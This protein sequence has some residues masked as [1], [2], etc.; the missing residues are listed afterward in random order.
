MRAST[1]SSPDSSPDERRYLLV[2]DAQG[3]RR[4]RLPDQG[5]ACIGRAQDADVRLADEQASRRHATLNLGIG[6]ATL[7]DLDSQNGTR[8][9][10]E[11]LQGSRL[12][13]SGDVISI[14]SST[15]VF[16][17]KHT[18]LV[19][20]TPLA[21]DELMR[22][23]E[24]ELERALRYQRPLTMAAIRIAD[25]DARPADIELA[26]ARGIRS[27]DVFSWARPDEV[28]ILMPELS[29]DDAFDVIGRLLRVI[30]PL[31]PRGVR[32]GFS[33]AP[34]D[35][36]DVAG[37][38]ESARAGTLMSTASTGDVV[39]STF[40]TLALGG[41]TIV[42]ADAV[43]LGIY[44]MAERLATSDL[45]VLISGETG[46]GKEL[47][48]GAIH[49]WSHRKSG[50]FVAVNC[51]AVSDSLAESELF[52]HEK[53]AF[54]GSLTAR[55]GVF[56]RAEGGTVFLDEVGELAAQTQAALLRVLETRRVQRL[57]A[58]REILVDFR[59]VSATNRD[60]TR[61]V[62]AGLFRQDLFYRLG[63]AVVRLPPLRE[64]SRE[65][66]VLAQA[67]L[68][69]ACRTNA[70][71][72]KILSMAATEMCSSYG[73]PGNVR[74]LKH[75]MDYL[76]ATVDESV[77]EPRH[78]VSM[79][80]GE[81]DLLTPPPLDAAF[82]RADNATPPASATLPSFRPLY[83]EIADLEQQRI[84]A[85]LQATDG[86]QTRAAALLAMP[87]RTF[88]AKVKQYALSHSV[89]PRHPERGPRKR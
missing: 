58:E 23:G 60:L 14:G 32:G 56:E 12:L 40:R 11:R 83:D 13:R 10:G 39:G 68:E 73:W 69:S 18:S 52:G 17:A 61:D 55:K 37:L 6:S 45:P 78:L 79:I 80:G 47:V 41:R 24:Q 77:I 67:L 59:L 85:A 2:V 33:T 88:Q 76:A 81:P 22:R 7:V 86:N 53:G 3:S 75:A 30:S 89:E 9:G 65:L 21:L 31:V 4:V 29:A 51:A 46:T 48:A 35:A 72:P 71:P 36:D 27:I 26:L 19:T 49:A 63:A 34:A 54:T 43:M 5:Q 50:P 84:S 28:L 74:E 8:V 42:V 20:Q 70:Q 1:E 16:Q 38:L 62:A 82:A 66:P 64:R 87:L 25:G 57:G 44:T 15:L